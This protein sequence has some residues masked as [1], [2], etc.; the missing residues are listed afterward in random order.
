MKKILVNA[1]LKGNLGDDLFIKALSERFPDETFVV[2]TKPQY[3]E[4]LSDLPNVELMP[5]TSTSYLSDSIVKVLSKLGIPSG[6]ILKKWRYKA[7][8]EIG[9][10]IFIQS[11]PR[12]TVTS[13]RRAW[14]KTKLPFFI[15]GSNFGP[16]ITEQYV[17][18][19]IDF[20]RNCSG[21]VFRDQFSYSFFDRLS[22][23]SVAPDVVFSMDLLTATKKK[24]LCISLISLTKE[25]R[26]GSS[27]MNSAAN[28]FEYK[29]R[30]QVKQA[31]LLG[32]EV[33]LLSFCDEQGDLQSAKRIY[34]GLTDNYKPY[35]R[36]VGG[37]N[38][39]EKLSIIAESE[40][41]ISCR[42]HAMI[43]GWMMG[44]KQ[45]T[46]AYS[47]KT[48]EVI[49]DVFPEQNHEDIL[50][51]AKRTELLD[52]SKFNCIGQRKLNEV[53]LESKKQFSYLSA[54][55]ND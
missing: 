37:M 48:T 2:N 52:F 1:W 26:P 4:G 21:V 29:I 12:R 8:V 54:F 34:D 43:L 50:D 11:S 53:K 20:F 45:Y 15:I 40:Y 22:S 28:A 42:Y 13:F 6:W 49:S 14:V 5:E 25:S 33:V 16:F 27:E 31:A 3:F 23:V 24:R 9:G 41:L 47:R 36:V 44:V 19:Y 32:F 55:L 17:H 30:E 38:I 7:V 35:V 10:S 18:D 51:Y 46:L 39:R